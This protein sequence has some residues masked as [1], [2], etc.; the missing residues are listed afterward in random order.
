MKFL[1]VGLGSMGKRRVRNLKRLGF[2]NIT[3]FDPRADR[4]AE[5]RTKYGIETT[6]DWATAESLP[7]DA[8]IISTPPDTH[9]DYGLKAVARRI[10]FFT[11]ANVPDPRASEMIAALKKSGTVGAPSCT[12]RYYFGPKKI[13]E[14]LEHKAIGK[15]LMFTYHTG[16]YLPDWHPWESYKD[17]Y[18]SRRDTGACREIVPFELAWLV[19]LFGGV[20][21]LTALRDKVS[22]LDCDIDDIYQLLMRFKSGLLAHLVVDVVS[23]PAFRVFRLCGSKGSIEWDHS[24]NVVKLWTPTD[25][26]N[27]Y[28]IETFDLGVGTVETGYIHT[29]EPYVEEMS[30]FLAACRGG[31]PWPYSYEDD[32]AVLKLLLHAEKS[33]DTGMRQS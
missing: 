25:K 23:R 17:F 32:E 16:Q 11:E 33:S 26:P 15:P 30:D 13:S 5:A 2:S 24:A 9:L 27:A 19:N 18:V 22:D 20:E 31:K 14:L 12:M 10:H 28:H 6:G 7:V 29:E 8:W 4:Q 1:I 21:I 3:G